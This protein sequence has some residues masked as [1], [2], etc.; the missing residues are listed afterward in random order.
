MNIL[1]TFFTT[2]P[3]P[4]QSL[5]FLFQRCKLICVSSLVLLS[6]LTIC[7][8]FIYVMWQWLMLSGFR[9]VLQLFPI[10]LLGPVLQLLLVLRF[11]W[12]MLASLMVI[13]RNLACKSTELTSFLSFT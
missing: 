7:V 9:L 5:S 2:S 11:A 1:N 6:N 12:R 10:L 13:A 4:S 8:C 3:S